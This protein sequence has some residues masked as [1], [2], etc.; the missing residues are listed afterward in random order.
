MCPERLDAWEMPYTAD[1]RISD[2]YNLRT[3]LAECIERSERLIDL[4]PMSPLPEPMT[5]SSRH[6]VALRQELI[7]KVVAHCFSAGVVTVED[8]KVEFSRRNEQRPHATQFNAVSGSEI[9]AKLR[10]LRGESSDKITS[11]RSSI[12]RHRQLSETLLAGENELKRLRQT[13]ARDEE[14]DEDDCVQ[15]VLPGVLPSEMV[16]PLNFAE[17]CADV[18]QKRLNGDIEPLLQCMQQG[19]WSVYGGCEELKRMN[20]SEVQH[21]LFPLDPIT[22]GDCCCCCCCCCCCY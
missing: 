6:R 19:F 13:L 10:E 7:N 20:V 11:L 17:Y 16:T 1:S 15:S 18:V 3:Y 12:A 14:R 8:I 4:E 5:P 9:R 2:F 22:A 21:K